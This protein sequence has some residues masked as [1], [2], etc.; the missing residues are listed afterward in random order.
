MTNRP[1]DGYAM[2][3]LLVAMSV[4][5]VIMSVAMPVWNTA[6]R[7]EK[8]EEL[9]FRGQQYARAITLFQRR[10]PGTFPP[11]IDILVNEK[12]LRKRYKD[13]ITN[14]D[15]QLI[16]VGGVIPGQGPTP[17]STQGQQQAQQGRGAF[18]AQPAPAR[19]GGAG[20]ITATTGV[21]GV[22]SK[23]QAQ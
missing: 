16:P 22:V 3:A 19:G 17:S 10:Y 23:S 13:P 18:P 8:E 21:M 11:N 6:T 1:D 14:D 7:R 20:Q 9:I 5:A 15:F 12:Y 2:A 4:M